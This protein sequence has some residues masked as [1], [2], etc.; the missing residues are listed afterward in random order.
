[1]S[2]YKAILDCGWRAVI[3]ESPNGEKVKFLATSI[4]DGHLAINNLK[5]VALKDVP[6]IREYPDVFQEDLPGMPLD[7]DIELVINLVI[8][9]SPVS[10][11]SYR[12]STDELAEMKK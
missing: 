1:M 11:V 6:V 10:K 8:G 5:A 7:W 3:L 2:K 4:R 12:M 9:T